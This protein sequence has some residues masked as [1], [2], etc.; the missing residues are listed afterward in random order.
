[1]DGL[2]L[3]INDDRADIAKPDGRETAL[4]RRG[5]GRKFLSEDPRG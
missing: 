4:K 1:M 3:I 2:I 5:K